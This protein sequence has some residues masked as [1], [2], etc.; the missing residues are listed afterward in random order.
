[1]IGS[2]APEPLQIGHGRIERGELEVLL[3]SVAGR[4]A[5]GSDGNAACNEVT[6]AILAL[7]EDPAEALVLEL[8]RLD[9]VWGDSVASWFVL[10][11]A[12]HRIPVRLVAEGD[13]KR[14]LQGLLQSTNLAEP[15]GVS[16]HDT[17][18]D[19]LRSLP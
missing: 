1:M 7:L 4:L 6:E 16:I 17:V 9:Y 15:L 2:R 18:A 5:A 8:L 10:S 11:A 12:R 3:V 13:T 19:A 14:A